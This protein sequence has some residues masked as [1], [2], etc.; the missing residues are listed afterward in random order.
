MTSIERFLADGEDV[1]LLTR[2][3]LGVL[4]RP[5]VRAVIVTA[6]VVAAATFVSPDDGSEWLDVAAGAV[7]IVMSLPVMW[8][9]LRWRVEEVAV[10]E[11]RVLAVTGLLRRKVTSIPLERVRN[12]ALARGVWGRLLGYG[13]IELDLGDHGTIVLERIRRPKLFYRLLAAY[14]AGWRPGRPVPDDEVPGDEDA[15]TG[16]LPRV[17]L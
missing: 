2:R 9:A 10:T 5:L 14:A 17:V 15:D 4:L 16:P 6:P 11:R 7:A 8:A 3:H 1:D 13:D 12:A